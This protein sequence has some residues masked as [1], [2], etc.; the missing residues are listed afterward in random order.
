MRGPGLG[1]ALRHK[2]G[3]NKKGVSLKFCHPGCPIMIVAGEPQLRVLDLVRES[4]VQAVI[5][6]KR[7]RHFI[8]SIDLMRQGSGNDPDLF[9]LSRE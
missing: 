1:V 3:R 7:F 8:F 6:R 4:L 9:L 2:Q 5:A